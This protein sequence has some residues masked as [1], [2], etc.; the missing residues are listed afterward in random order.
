MYKRFEDLKVWQEARR[1]RQK[2]YSLLT[3]FPKTEQYALSSQIWRAAISITSNIAEGYGRFHWQENIQC[4]RISRG[5]INET[6]DQLYIAKDC[7]YISSENFDCLYNE[8][9]KIEQLLNG[10]IRYLDKQKKQAM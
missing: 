7:G 3:K 9:R 6:L 8:G 5:S 4:C 2:I 10:Y 1:Y